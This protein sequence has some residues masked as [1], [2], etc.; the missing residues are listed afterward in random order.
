M[1]EAIIAAIAA[2]GGALVAAIGKVIVDVIKAKKE[3]DNSKLNIAIEELVDKFN[4]RFD[5]L[6]KKINENNKNWNDINLVELRHSIT[7]IYYKY[8]DEKSF[9]RNMKEDVCSLYAAY[10]KLGGNSYIHI[11]YEE[12][13][14]WEVK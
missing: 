3:P 8:C 9:P 7:E 12:M 14:G 5:E 4:Q 1:N 11:I 6:D 2:G 13:M 10:V